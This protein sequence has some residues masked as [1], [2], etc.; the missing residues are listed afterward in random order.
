MTRRVESKNGIMNVRGVRT[1]TAVIE[2]ARGRDAVNQLRIR[3][4]RR[5]RR[6]DRVSSIYPSH[7]SLRPLV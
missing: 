1:F 6:L 7:I 3:S 2:L 5:R 4:S